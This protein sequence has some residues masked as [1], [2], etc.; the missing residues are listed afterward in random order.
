MSNKAFAA[1]AYIFWIPSLYI[2]LTEL[3]KREFIGFHGGQALRL[4]LWIFV[5]FFSFRF[6]VNLIWGV[7]Y[8]P[9]LDIL[10]NLLGLG[11]WAYA[12]YCGWRC[13]QGISFIIPH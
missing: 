10:E 13:Y 3:R 9:G 4:W 1:L 6:L 11:L 7:F 2:V 12:A 5:I 8:V